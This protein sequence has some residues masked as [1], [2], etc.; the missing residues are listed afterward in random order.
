MKIF[1]KI[2]QGLGILTVDETVKLSGEIAA[3][4]NKKMLEEYPTLESVYE[5]IK[6][7]RYPTFDAHV[8]I[9]MIERLKDLERGFLNE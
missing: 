3:A 8:K 9:M 1:T 5:H 4:R 7:I 6:S 2:R